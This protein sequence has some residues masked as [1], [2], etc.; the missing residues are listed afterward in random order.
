M[1]AFQ[2]SG[3]HMYSGCMHLVHTQQLQD[4]KEE[5]DKLVPPRWFKDPL[6]TGP[7]KGAVAYEGDPSKLFDEAL[8]EYWKT[9]GWTEDKGIPTLETLKELG[10]ADVAE[11]IA[12]QHL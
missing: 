10:I 7:Q 5:W 2:E 11:D 9:R 8:P 4:P 1:G 3:T 6:P 12:K